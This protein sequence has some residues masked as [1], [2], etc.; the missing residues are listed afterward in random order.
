LS[1]TGISKE[2]VI[3][4][5]L[6]SSSKSRDEL[7]KLIDEKK[8]KFSGLLTD[9]G[10][11]F[12]IAKELGVELSS[13]GVSKLKLA[14]LKTGETGLNLKLRLMHV[15]S[16]K[17]F[18]KNGK[19]GILCNAI[20]ADDT[21]EMRLTFWRDD[22]KKLFDEKI[23]RGAQIALS[24]VNVSSYNEQKQLSIGFGGT[25]NKTDFSEP[26]IPQPKEKAVKIK[27]LKENQNNVDLFAKVNRVYGERSFESNGRSGKVI[28]FEIADETKLI[29]AAA[30]NELVEYVTQLTPGEIIKIEGAYTK[31]GLNGIELNLGWQARIIQS[32]K[33]IS[34]K[35]TVADFET[36]KLSELIESSNAHV[37]AKIGRIE[38]G[39]LHY[40]VCPDCGKKLEREDNEYTCLKCQEIK[41]PD[42]NLVVG[43]TLVDGD[44]SLR[45]VLF[46]KQAEMAIS[47]SKEEMKKLLEEKPPEEI[48]EELNSK[49]V[50]KEISVQGS[51]RK[52]ATTDENEL[53]VQRVEA[54]N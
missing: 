40:F 52:N 34:I 25:F 44:Y 9:D 28:N 21:K 15:F 26:E 37:K 18:E 17:K 3:E 41:E 5:I 24:N 6:V 43:I 14:D 23:E 7:L 19:A 47:V 16:P 42:I 36:K 2:T 54:V 30:W 46:G 45:S 10:A 39:K 11:A 50:G 29:R 13:N 8:A 31:E 48:V 38:N 4:K 51:V 35:K 49:L 12:M 27:E 20:V 22:V 32:P 53:I 33:D 1:E